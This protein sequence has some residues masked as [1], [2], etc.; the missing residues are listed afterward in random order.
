MIN[1]GQQRHAN[2]ELCHQHEPWHHNAA[3]EVGLTV[4]S[5]GLSGDARYTNDQPYSDTYGPRHEGFDTH[6]S[7]NLDGSL[8]QKSGMDEGQNLAGLAHVTR[9]SPT[10]H[11]YDTHSSFNL[12]GSMRDH[13]SRDEV[14]SGNGGIT[15]SVRCAFSN[16]KL[17]SRMPLG[18]YAFAWL[19]VLRAF[20]LND[21]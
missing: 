2:H 15:G 5:N 19:E 4:G 6:S 20:V 10:H 9:Y 16:R 21:Q 13:V 8:K 3:G 11:G 7:F 18:L 12:D 17:H 14:W 1:S